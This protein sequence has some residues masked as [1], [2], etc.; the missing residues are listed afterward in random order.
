MYLTAFL[1]L[2]PFAMSKK[3]VTYEELKAHD[4]KDS[5]YLL[6]NGKGRIKHRLL[7]TVWVH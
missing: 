7:S 1:S 2:Q 6:I 4:T 5:L 3:I